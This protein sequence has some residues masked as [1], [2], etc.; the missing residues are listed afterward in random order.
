[1]IVVLELSLCS[2]GRQTFTVSS[3]RT[4]S[5]LQIRL[6]GAAAEFDVLSRAQ[7]TSPWLLPVSGGAAG[8][9]RAGAALQRL[10]ASLRTGHRMEQSCYLG[11]RASAFAGG[12]KQNQG[13]VALL[14]L[15]VW[16][17]IF[18]PYFTFP[19]SLFSLGLSD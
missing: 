5:C 19:S 6:R 4:C 13:D 8:G 14:S 18:L 11:R 1:M 2:T 15:L 3:S 9:L 17:H 16:S 12:F 10:G 7:G